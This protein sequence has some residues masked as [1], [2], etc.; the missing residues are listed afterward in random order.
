LRRERRADR[1]RYA[2]TLD[3]LMD[4]FGDRGGLGPLAFAA[5]AQLMVAAVDGEIPVPETALDRLRLAE[6]ARIAHGIARLEAGE[7]TANSAVMR[8]DLSPEKAQEQLDG[9]VARIASLQES[10]GPS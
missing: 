1:L 4:T 10:D 7:S 5:T 6:T 8:M 2:E 9:L 3:Y